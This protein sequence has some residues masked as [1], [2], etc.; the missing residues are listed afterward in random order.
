[1]RSTNIP[2]SVQV[3]VEKYLRLADRDLPEKILAFYVVG[4]LALNDYQEGL[5]DIDFVAVC[6]GPVSAKEMKK[7]EGLHGDLAAEFDKPDFDGVYVTPEQLR[8]APDGTGI[9]SYQDK[10]L[11][12]ARAFN[13]NPVTWHLLGSCPVVIRGN[14]KP[15]V[16]ANT[17]ELKEW[18]KGNVGGYW[19]S[20][21]DKANQKLMNPIEADD[22]NIIWGVLGI[23]RLHATIATGDVISKSGAAA[24][25]KQVFESKWHE[26]VERVAS[27]RKN[28]DAQGDE[29]SLIQK[30]NA[31]R[32]MDRVIVDALS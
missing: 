6:D 19:K 3:P 16:Y 5:S 11:R 23:T 28:R 4:S 22:V 9:A 27:A 26:I 18:C 30:R 2:E 31:L 29:F 13:A 12:T 20:W 10:K 24:Y 17:A 8:L 25:A 21:T 32:F 14:P 7:I 15:A 1:M